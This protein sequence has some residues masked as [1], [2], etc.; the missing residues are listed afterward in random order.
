MTLEEAWRPFSIQYFADTRG[1]QE[2][3]DTHR[4]DIRRS[5]PYSSDPFNL[6]VSTT[7]DDFSTEI[8]I[9]NSNTLLGH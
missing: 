8:S 3:Q 4:Q 7:N 5:E 2:R 1:G 6:R 9:T